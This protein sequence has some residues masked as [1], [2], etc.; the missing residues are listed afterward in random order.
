MSCC[1]DHNHQD[2]QSEHHQHTQQHTPTHEAQKK[3]D[4]LKGHNDHHQGKRQ[5]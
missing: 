1:G 4:L 3:S 2:H 5:S